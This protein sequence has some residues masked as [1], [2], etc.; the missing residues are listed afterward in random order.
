MSIKK[1]KVSTYLWF[2][3]IHKANIY[4]GDWAFSSD[5]IQICTYAEI[6]HPPPTA[7]TTDILSWL[8]CLLND[9]QQ[10]KCSRWFRCCV[11]YWCMDLL[12]VISNMLCARIPLNGKTQLI[13]DTLFHPSAINM[14]VIFSD[15]WIIPLPVDVGGEQGLQGWLCVHR[16]WTRAVNEGET[17]CSFQNTS[18]TICQFQSDDVNRRITFGVPVAGVRFQ[19]G[20]GVDHLQPLLE[21]WGGVSVKWC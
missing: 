1:R 4:S 5:V 21:D 15:P 3:E 20:A 17:I 10:H 18:N 13:N 8:N 11:L 14:N 16:V 7:P 19:T 9:V 6:I 12:S 2:T